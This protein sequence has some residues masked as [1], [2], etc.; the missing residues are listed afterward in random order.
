MKKKKAFISSGTPMP[1]PRCRGN[2]LYWR[3]HRHPNIPAITQYWQKSRQLR[4]QNVHGQ[5]MDKE[6]LLQRDKVNSARKKRNKN[7]PQQHEWKEGRK[8]RT[9]EKGKCHVITL[10]GGFYVA[11]HKWEDSGSRRH[12]QSYSR[13]MLGGEDKSWLAETYT[14]THIHK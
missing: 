1:G 2:L 12:T 6:E 13:G 9:A 14:H 10:G 8:A 7:I 4:G 3:R 11:I 5:W